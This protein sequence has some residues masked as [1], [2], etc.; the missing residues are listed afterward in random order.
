MPQDKGDA[1]L[2]TE[3]GQPV[4]G[5]HTCDGHDEPLAVRGD[6]HQQGFRCGLHIAVEQDVSIVTQDADVQAPRVQ[7]NTTVK[8]G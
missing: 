4:P 1:L 2:R 7:I 3:V 8:G 6:G 5:K